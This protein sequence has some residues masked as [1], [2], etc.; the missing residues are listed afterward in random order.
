MDLD[1][2]EYLPDDGFLDFHEVGEKKV[3]FGKSYFDSKSVF[4]VYQDYCIIQSPDSSNSKKLQ[5]T[6]P[7][8]VAPNQLALPVQI[9]LNHPPSFCRSTQTQDGEQ[10]TSLVPISSSALN[11]G[12]IGGGG[13]GG[14]QDPL[15]SQVYFKKTWEP[16]FVDMKMDSPKSPTRGGLGF[17]HQTSADSAAAA[18]GGGKF[19][20]DDKDE[21]QVS[22]PRMKTNLLETK[23][24]EQGKRQN[25]NIWNLSFTGIGAICSFGFAAATICILFLGSHHQNH[26][27]FHIST[28]DNKR[29]KDVVHQTTKLNEAFSAVGGRGVPLTRAHITSGGYYTA[30]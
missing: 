16:E 2:W 30:L 19:Q 4:N 14:D 27:R 17:V 7:V 9:Q 13:D 6:D 12:I 3:F 21:P 5:I 22:S 8:A 15:L 18:G 24:E 1:E 10:E 20:F 25:H 29:I 28:H 11:S 26:K 23:E